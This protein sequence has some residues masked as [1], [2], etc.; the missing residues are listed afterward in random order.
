[1]TEEKAINLAGRII[2]LVLMHQPQKLEYLASVDM[3]RQ[4]AQALAALR[5]E[6]IGQL[7]QQP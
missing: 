7:K 2:E 6:L 4:T 5:L 1:M 3:A